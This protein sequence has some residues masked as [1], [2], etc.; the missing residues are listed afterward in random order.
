M[1]PSSGSKNKLAACLNGL[2]F[3]HE[4]GDSTFYR[5]VRKIVPDYTASH[6]RRQYYICFVSQVMPEMNILYGIGLAD[7]TY[8]ENS[9][10]LNNITGPEDSLQLCSSSVSII[11]YFSTGIINI[12]YNS[13][14]IC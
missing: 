1:P 14:Y 8:C 9:N 12:L 2:L 4:D 10:L 13:K 6:P 7:Y 5:N 3:D 11:L